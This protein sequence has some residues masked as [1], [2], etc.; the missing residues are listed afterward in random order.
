MAQRGLVHG[1]QRLFKQGP[2]GRAKHSGKSV[3][4]GSVY[5]LVSKIEGFRINRLRLPLRA[6]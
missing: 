1:V 4:I 3:R 5:W 2:A 6:L